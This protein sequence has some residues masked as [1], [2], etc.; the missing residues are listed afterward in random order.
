M[1]GMGYVL[2]EIW[3]KWWKVNFLVEFFKVIEYKYSLKLHWKIAE[4]L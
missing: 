1:D 2:W 4:E 3:W